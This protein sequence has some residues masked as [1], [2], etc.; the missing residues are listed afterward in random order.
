MDNSKGLIPTE[1]IN[2]IKSKNDIV[3]YISSQQSLLLQKNNYY[4]E[5]PICGKSRSFVVYPNT[6]SFYC[7]ACGTG[8]DIISYVMKTKNVDYKSA[9]SE[10]AMISGITLSETEALAKNLMRDAAMFYHSQL[11][12]NSNANRA[13]EKLH[14]WGLKGK[15]IVKLGIGFHDKSFNCFIEYMTKEKTYTIAQ[16][17]KANL[18]AKSSNEKYFDKM[19]DSV[20]IPTVDMEG[21]VVCFDYYV[22]GKDQLYKYPSIG[23][24]DRSNYLYSLNLATHTEKKCVIIVSSYEDYFQ[25]FGMGITNVVATY[26]PK[27]TS[28]QLK[29]LKKHFKVV[30]SFLPHYVNFSLCKQYCKNNNMFY[31]DIS[32]QGCDSP[33]EYLK[34]YGCRAITEK[35][36]EFER[37]L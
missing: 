5:C 15:N 14:S 36:D 16:L 11:K 2:K 33:V 27:I 13:I 20:I 31:E 3:D 34:K 1:I 6:K 37:L 23:K 30:I 7:F 4:G 12:T 17:K 32:L 9:V 35:I 22:I 18:I 21:N 25:L 8:G 19:M 10:L 28:E 24:F 29:L 26:L